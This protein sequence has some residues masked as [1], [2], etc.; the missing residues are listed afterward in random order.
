MKQKIITTIVVVV[1]FPLLS[2]AQTQLEWTGATSNLEVH[3]K[4]YFITN[5]TEQ[6]LDSLWYVGMVSTA[7]S[8]IKELSLY[9]CYLQKRIN[10]D[11]HFRVQYEGRGFN[12][13]KWNGLKFSLGKKYSDQLLVGVS[14]DYNSEKFSNDYLIKQYCFIEPEGAYQINN[15]FRIYSRISLSVTDR[16]DRLNQIS[17]AAIFNLS[18]QLSFS[19]NSIVDKLNARC[20]IGITYLPCDN[21]KLNAQLDIIQK[22]TIWKV[23]LSKKQMG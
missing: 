7:P 4:N 17:L 11:F 22:S 1:L 6:P 10:S 13:Y 8:S 19:V 16:K 9:N 5:V 12:Q 3:S 23:E 2:K 20:D 14:V 21:L 18:K 15:Q